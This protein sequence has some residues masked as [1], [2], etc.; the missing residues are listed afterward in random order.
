MKKRPEPIFIILIVAATLRALHIL[1]YVG[2]KQMDEHWQVFEPAYGL[3]GYPWSKTIEWQ[4]GLRNW[5]YPGLVAGVIKLLECLRVD[6]QIVKAQIVRGLHGCLSLVGI[7]Y[8]IRLAQRLKQTG[9]KQMSASEVLSWPSAY[10]VGIWL[11]VLPF[12]IYTGVHCHGDML[13]AVFILLAFYVSPRS[14]LASG[15]FYGLAL[16]IKIDLAVAGLFAGLWHLFCRQWNKAFQM[17]LGALPFILLTGFIDW[18]TWGQWFH[19]VLGHA[20]VNLVEEIG[21]QWGTSPWFMHLAYVASFVGVPALSIFALLNKWKA[22]ST[23]QKHGWFVIFGFI[24]VFS[25]VEHKEK[26]FMAPLIYVAVVYCF[27][28][29]EWLLND[30]WPRLKHQ[31]SRTAILAIAFVLSSVLFATDIRNYII[32]RPWHER[33]LSIWHGSKI[34]DAEAFFALQWPAVFYFPKHIPATNLDATPENIKSATQSYRVVAVVH[35]GGHMG[36][37]QD[38]GFQCAVVYPKSGVLESNAPDPV[39]RAWR[40]ERNPK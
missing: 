11:A 28:F 20:R 17:A 5:I 13:G 21:N 7:Y 25:C 12:S 24:G 19:S 30:Y 37:W 38:A 29:A 14:A 23:E 3:L 34:A 27:V 18:L 35:D 15:A 9:F 2:F 40:C 32:K 22:L 1:G 16:M 36:W 39:P 6:D 31:F 4:D 10:A 8:A 26:R 33:I